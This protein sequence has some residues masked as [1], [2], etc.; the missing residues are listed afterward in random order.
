MP[1]AVPGSY[2]MEKVLA[3]GEHLRS[4]YSWTP[5]LTLFLKPT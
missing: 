1:E 2:A 3:C 4:E 5:L